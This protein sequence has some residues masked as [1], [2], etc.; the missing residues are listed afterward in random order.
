MAK[1][2]S[3]DEFMQGLDRSLSEGVQLLRQAILASDDGITGHVKWNAPSFCVDGVD[4]VTFRTSGRLVEQRWQQ[5]QHHHRPGHVG[6]DR[7][8][9]PAR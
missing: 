2:Q 3:V 1:A 6:D 8:Q 5:E 9:D 4:R 7:C